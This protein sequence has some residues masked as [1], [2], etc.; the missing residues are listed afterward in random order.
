VQYS[1]PERIDDL[2]SLKEDIWALGVII[3]YLSSFKMPFDSEN[4]KISAIMRKIT[5]A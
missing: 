4:K 2:P 5:D 3:Y 1:S